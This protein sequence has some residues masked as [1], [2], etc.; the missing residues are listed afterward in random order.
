M[1]GLAAEDH[2]PSSSGA[3]TPFQEAALEEL[4]RFL[5]STGYRFVTPTPATHARVVSR[6]R[7]DPAGTVQDVLGWSLPFAAGRIDPTVERLLG[8]ADMLATSVDGFQRSRIRVSSLCDRLYLHSAFPTTQE[9]AV[10]FGPDSYRFANLLREELRP[11]PLKGNDLLLDIGT[12][13]GVGAIVAADMAPRARV[14][15]TDLNDRALAFATINARHAGKSIEVR[16]CRGLGDDCRDV[17]VGF[18]NPPYI[19]DPAR[20]AYRDGG[21][22]HGGEMSVSIIRSALPALSPDGRFILYTGSAIVDGRDRLRAELQ[23]LADQHGRHLRYWEI[24]PDVFGEELENPEYAEVDR[25]AIVG[26]VFTPQA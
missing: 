21:G 7:S 13:A 19:I 25:I 17:A 5:H 14:V 9:D 26:A 2:R 4:L 24:D 3:L 11:V 6:R 16:H 1:I 10:F 23:A 18:A 12:G 22:M 15:M 20:R 8:E